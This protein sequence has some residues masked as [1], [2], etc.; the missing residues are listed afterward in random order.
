MAGTDKWYLGLPAWAFPGWKDRYMM[1]APSRLRSY[2]SVFNTVEGN[3]TFYRVP[4]ARTVDRW[5]SAVESREFRFSF[6]LPRDVTHERRP[7]AA[8]LQAFIDVLRALEDYL[9]PFLVQFPATV[10]PQEIGA[11]DAV[12][13][14]LA[15][16]HRFVVEVRHP[17]FF[18]DPSLL[19]PILD[20]FGAGRIVL[21]SRPLYRGDRSHPDVVEALH[22]KPD[23]PVIPDVHN[24]VTLIRLILHPDIVSNASYIEEWADRVADYLRAGV[25]TYMMI[26]CPNNLHCPP[27]ARDFHEALQRRLPLAD[28]PAWPV[29]AEQ[30]ALPFD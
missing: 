8:S 23:L 6:K 29:P 20:R 12:F 25:E 17:A 18:E 9:A 2:A 14:K 1:D 5:R 11:F 4:D 3:T 13:G 16:R 7:D 15:E 21:D 10:G 27:L 26:H 19:Q 28:F 30:Q 22:V 24:G